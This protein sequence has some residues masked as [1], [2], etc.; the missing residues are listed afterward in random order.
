MR[1]EN[2]MNC[3]RS[4][5]SNAIF[6]ARLQNRLQE[7][8]EIKTLISMIARGLIDQDRPAVQQLIGA[9]M[10]AHAATLET[11]VND[12]I[13][14]ARQGVFGEL[15]LMVD[16]KMLDRTVQDQKSFDAIN[17][18]L[19]SREKDVAWLKGEMLSAQNGVQRAQAAVDLV[20]AQGM[21]AELGMTQQAMRQMQVA[22]KDFCHVACRKKEVDALIQAAVSK[23][24]F[25]A[26][27]DAQVGGQSGQDQIFKVLERMILASEA[28]QKASLH[29]IEK[30]L[31]DMCMKLRQKETENDMLKAK[32]AGM[33]ARLTQI[34]F[35]ET[36]RPLS[37]PAPSLA[38]E[39]SPCHL[40]W[41]LQ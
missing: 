14:K 19:M 30:D 36:L 23:V 33:E 32:L 22:F 12:H 15:V 37:V 3:A 16:R 40:S 6:D 27:K 38:P 24:Q 8:F 28:K 2:G 25:E 1:V 29:T 5:A 41:Y 17:Q 4:E 39:I 11:S 20:D 13:E 10:A 34:E 9:A 26:L 21:R 31:T 18:K 7:N 35:R